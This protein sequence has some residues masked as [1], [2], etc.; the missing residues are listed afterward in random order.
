MSVILI[1][2]YI[3]NL[4]ITKYPPL[5]SFL[6]GRLLPMFSLD[7]SYQSK[8]NLNFTRKIAYVEKLCEKSKK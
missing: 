1:F 2:L 6:T 3:L 5:F 4:F 8:W 7:Y